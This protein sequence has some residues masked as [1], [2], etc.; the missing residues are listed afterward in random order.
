MVTPVHR[1]Q[2][3]IGHGRNTL[4][5]REL[6]ALGYRIAYAVL[7]LIGLVC[8]RTPADDRPQDLARTPPGRGRGTYS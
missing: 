8:P 2:G 7:M 3:C 4:L 5:H 6:R 1:C